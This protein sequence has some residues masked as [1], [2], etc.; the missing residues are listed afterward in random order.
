LR[1][2]VL[3]SGQGTDGAE[4]VSLLELGNVNT[5]DL[6]VR[7]NHRIAPGHVLQE[8]LAIAGNNLVAVYVRPDHGVGVHV[9]PLGVGS[10]S[11]AGFDAARAPFGLTIA[12]VGNRILVGWD[13]S[14]AGLRYGWLDA[15]GAQ[16][17]AVQSFAGEFGAPAVT[18]AFGGALWFRDP[19]G[20]AP[21]LGMVRADGSSRPSV[22]AS[23]RAVTPVSAVSA[24][25]S[26]TGAMLVYTSGNS[27]HLAIVGGADGSGTDRVIGSAGIASETALAGTT[28]GAFAAWTHEGAIRFLPVARD[29]HDVA[30]QF[31]VTSNGPGER[32]RIPAVAAIDS[33]AYVV[34]SATG[35][36]SSPSGSGVRMVRV[37][38]Q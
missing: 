3:Y 26:G 23:S 13:E 16:S 1:L 28:W 7:G 33:T 11:S 29:G 15:Q 9:R 17:G 25:A 31:I 35:L 5:D 37:V 27:A 38:C 18:A 34:F 12:T 24:T 30:S 6:I 14:P 8:G 19:T 36:S 20:G 22:S 32:A 10:T 4:A 2:W 21:R